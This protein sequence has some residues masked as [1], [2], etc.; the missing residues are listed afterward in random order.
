MDV[1]G[2]KV[3]PLVYWPHRLLHTT[4][5]ED[6]SQFNSNVVIHAQLSVEL[7]SLAKSENVQDKSSLWALL[8]L[9]TVGGMC[10]CCLFGGM[11]ACIF[12]TEVKVN[13]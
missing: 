9:V 3:V 10:Y 13:R 4:V 11:I 7:T 6:F 5:L 8:I 12:N 2:V 1:H